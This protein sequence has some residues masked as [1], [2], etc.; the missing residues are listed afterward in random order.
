MISYNSEN[1][2]QLENEAEISSWLEGVIL[3]ENFKLGEINYIFCSDEYLHKL[4]VEF[5]QHDTLTDIISF[6]YT[7]GKLIQ[8]DI[9]ISTER[10]ADN[11]KD[12]NVSFTE[13]VHRVMV[14]GIL[15]YCGFKDKTPEDEKLMR[16]K[17]NHYLQLLSNSQ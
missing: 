5:L 15:H 13:E 2:F 9:Y 16:E 10:V 8:G 17:E 12:F 6:D 4:N 3:N 1:T 14:H 7:V 11:A